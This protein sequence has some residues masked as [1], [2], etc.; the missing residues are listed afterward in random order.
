M[1][2]ISREPACSA[3]R[4]MNS[5]APPNFVKKPKTAGWR[6][7]WRWKRSIDVPPV[8]PEKTLPR[9]GSSSSAEAAGASASRQAAARSMGRRRMSALIGRRA[10]GL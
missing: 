5:L 8:I 6:P 9:G 2:S 10:R 3:P 4:K 7:V 1:C